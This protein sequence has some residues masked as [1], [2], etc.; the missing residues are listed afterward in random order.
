[1]TPERSD[2]YRRVLHTLNELG[3]SKLQD[4]EQERLRLAVDSLVFARDLT[5]DPAAQAGLEDT[6]KLCHDLVQSGRWEQVT[7]MRLFDDVSHCGPNRVPEL[8]AA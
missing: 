6:E 8:E 4:V 5:E 3:P 2:A 7:A 1:M